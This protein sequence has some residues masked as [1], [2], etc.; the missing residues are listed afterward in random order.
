MK[1]TLFREY[2][3]LLNSY[4]RLSNDIVPYAIR[5]YAKKTD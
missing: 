4:N 2:N 5:I 1:E 3:L